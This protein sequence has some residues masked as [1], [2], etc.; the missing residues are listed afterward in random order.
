MKKDDSHVINRSFLKLKKDDELCNTRAEESQMI[1]STSSQEFHG[2]SRL[3]EAQSGVTPRAWVK[4]KL[5]RLSLKQALH[6][7]GGLSSDSTNCA[8]A[9]VGS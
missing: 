6:G 7:A 1:D 5:E 2:P 8:T 4:P 3:T 9:S